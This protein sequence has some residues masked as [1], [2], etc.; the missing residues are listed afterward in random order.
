MTTTNMTSNS[1]PTKAEQIYITTQP[2][3]DEQSSSSNETEQ[4]FDDINSATDTAENETITPTNEREDIDRDEMLSPWKDCL[5]MKGEDCCD[6][7]QTLSS[8][9]KQCLLLPPTAFRPMDFVA[10]RVFVK[11]N[12]SNIVIEVPMKG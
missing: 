5:N 4:H 1:T 8:E 3:D 6:F 9:I 12:E 11:T 7:I 2:A 10:S